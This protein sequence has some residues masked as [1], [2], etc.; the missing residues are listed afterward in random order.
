M[1]FRYS[2][3]LRAMPDGRL[4]VNFPEFPEARTDG[5]DEAEAL[6]EAAD[7]LETVLAHRLRAGEKIPEPSPT[8]GHPM[9]APRAIL[10]AK[11]GLHLAMHDAG[12]SRVA[13]T[14]RLECDEREVWRLLDPR[15]PSKITRLERALALLGRRLVI[16]VEKA[17]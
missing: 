17:A 6:A 4:L 8:R 7:C 2:V 12:L 9:V 14:K 15:Y 3:W 16:D 11:A 1:N 13:L 10:A 5:A